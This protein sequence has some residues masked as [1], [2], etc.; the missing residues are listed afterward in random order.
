MRPGLI[1]WVETTKQSRYSNCTV[2][3]LMQEPYNYLNCT[4]K[5]A[6]IS[7]IIDNIHTYGYETNHVSAL[8]SITSSG[9][10]LVS[11]VKRTYPGFAIVRGDECL[12]L[13]QIIYISSFVD[14][15]QGETANREW[16]QIVA[17]CSVDFC[18]YKISQLFS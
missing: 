16:I 7:F 14:Y 11:C 15:L 18:Q 2:N 6:T 12:Q 10:I 1:K 13:L 4:S 5:L 3:P 8:I 17:L 9:S